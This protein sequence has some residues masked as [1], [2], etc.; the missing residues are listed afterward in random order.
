MRK[1]VTFWMDNQDYL[2][3]HDVA[4][5]RGV[6]ISEF[7]RGLIKKELEESNEQGL[8]T[9]IDEETAKEIFGLV[10]EEVAE[11]LE[12]G[13]WGGVKKDEVL[14]HAIAWAQRRYPDKHREIGIFSTIIEGFA[15]GLWGGFGQDE[16][17]LFKDAYAM[18]IK[19]AGGT[20]PNEAGFGLLP[21]LSRKQKILLTKD[22]IEALEEFLFRQKR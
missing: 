21:M 4:E 10:D 19:K 16:D 22:I 5:R 2:R 1:N 3:L 17:P 9:L 12:K 7:L 8:F 15:T 11:E 14:G 13:G 18:V 6:S 20:P